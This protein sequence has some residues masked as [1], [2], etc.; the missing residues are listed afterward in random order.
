MGNC[1]CKI[2]AIDKKPD[3]HVGCCNSVRFIEDLHFEKYSTI[4]KYLHGERVSMKFITL[5]YEF[6]PH[7]NP[8]CF[9]E[10]TLLQITFVSQLR[11]FFLQHLLFYLKINE[12]AIIVM[13]YGANAWDFDTYYPFL[14]KILL[15]RM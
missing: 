3:F 7:T 14:L 5:L 13:D 11:D 8:I 9:Q 10:H 12:V 6:I 4:S 15:L 1:A 2:T